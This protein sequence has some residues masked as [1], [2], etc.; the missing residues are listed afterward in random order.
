MIRTRASPIPGVGLSGLVPHPESAA[1]GGLPFA[2]SDVRDFRTHRPCMRIDDPSAPCGRFV[3]R[4]TATVTT[5]DCRPGRGKLFPAADTAFALVF[6]IPSRGAAGSAEAPAAATSF[7]EHASPTSSTLPGAD[8]AGITDPAAS[9][10]SPQGDPPTPTALPPSGRISARTRRRTAAASG[11]EP[12]AVDYGF[13]P[14]GA[15]RPSTRRATTPPR[16]PRP[17]P[18]LAVA[19]TPTPSRLA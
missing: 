16:V 17:R 4:V 1:L 10:P 18:P 19:T 13:G 14:G 11:A 7:A 12:P 9:A 2:S 8:S 3:A 5:D 15:P 6:A